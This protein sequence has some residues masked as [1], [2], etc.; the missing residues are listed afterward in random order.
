MVKRIFLIGSVLLGFYAVPIQGY[1]EGDSDIL[2]IAQMTRMPKVFTITIHGGFDGN[3]AVTWLDPRELRVGRGE[4]VIWIN[5][6]QA[7]LRIKFGG[8]SGCETVPIKSFGW[9]LVPDRCFESK[10]ALLPKE[11]LSIRFRDIGRYFYEIEYVGK[12]RIEKGVVH[13]R[14]E[15]R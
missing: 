10:E 9:R 7:D 6:S 11:T 8:D 12:S 14:T 5:E 2:T 13:V 3:N 4:T 1:P 15:D